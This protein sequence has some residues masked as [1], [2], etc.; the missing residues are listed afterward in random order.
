[1]A[2]ELVCGADCWCNRHCMTSPVVLEG[3]W[4]QVWPKIGRK[5]TQKSE[6]RIANEPLSFC[7]AVTQAPVNR[8]VLAQSGRE[9]G[10]VRKSSSVPCWPNLDFPTAPRVLLFC[11]CS[12]P[13][14]G[15]NIVDS[16]N[17]KTRQKRRNE[18]CTAL[19][20]NKKLQLATQ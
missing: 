17:P 18:Y 13:R 5:P 11:F 7:F 2:L 10:T 12:A 14:L 3:C 8:V 9:R 1:M 16:T 6:F 15:L 19:S 20:G 4:G